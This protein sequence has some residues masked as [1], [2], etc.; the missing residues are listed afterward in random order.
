MASSNGSSLEER[1]PERGQ[2]SDGGALPAAANLAEMTQV[3]E[4]HEDRKDDETPVLNEVR[5]VV[6]TRSHIISDL[7][8][9]PQ[10]LVLSFPQ[11]VRKHF[12]FV[13]C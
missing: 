8:H 2:T 3:G 12:S 7:S 1:M 13:S 11:P 5:S 6:C 4:D 10:S 9:V